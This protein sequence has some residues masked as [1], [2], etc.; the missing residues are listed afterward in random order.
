MELLYLVINDIGPFRGNHV[1]DFNGAEGKTGFAIFSKNG[2]G[3]T[4]LFN[5][6]QWCLFGEVYERGGVRSGK[7]ADGRKRKIV[8]E[9][10]KDKPL[11]NQDAYEEDDIP[12]MSVLII[13]DNEGEEI[14]ISRTAKSRV[15]SMPRHDEAME[16]RLQVT[17]GGKSTGDATSGQ[18]LIEELFPS[19]LR[20]FFFIDGESLEEYV[21][22]VKAGQVGGIKDDVEAVLRIPALTRGIDD[23]EKVRNEVWDELD[24]A[25]KR[26]SKRV[27]SANQA[28][29]VRKEMELMK[30]ELA[31][32]ESRYDNTQSKLE[33]LEEKLKGFEEAEGHI[34]NIQALRATKEGLTTSLGRSTESRRAYASNSWKSLIWGKAEL[35]HRDANSKM[36]VIQNSNYRIS[37]TEKRLRDLEE[38]LSKWSGY[39]SHCSQSIDDAE[40][41]KA[42]IEEKIEGARK[43]LVELQEGPGIS[44]K[45]LQMMIGDLVKLSPPSGDRQMIAKTDRDWMEDRA[46]LRDV[47]EKLEK[48]E[49]RGLEG[50]DFS[51]INKKFED[52]GAMRTSLSRMRPAIDEMKQNLKRAQL[53]YK[54]LGGEDVESQ[55]PKKANMNQTIGT[56]L[57]VMK[58]TLD[59]YR[60]G[61]RK[62]VE[63]IAS[64]TFRNVINAPETLT[65]LVIDINFNGSIVGRNGRPLSMPSSGQEMIMT[66]CIM[67]ALRQAS[68]VSAPIFFD[69]PGRSVDD[70]HKKAQLEYFWRVREHQF[71][72][73]PHTGEY[74]VEE[75]LDDFGGLIG[76][77][78]ELK[79]P[80]DYNNCIS[81]GVDSPLKKGGKMVCL[82]CN[83]EWVL[84]S[85]TTVEKLE[86]SA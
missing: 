71:V 60:E 64:T 33:D 82:A 22:L 41:H 79:W 15:G 12:E 49:E 52:R 77:A 1:F 37:T 57:N 59:E 28:G 45:A 67:D 50:L 61:A 27:K 73:F 39:C 80:E 26:R 72:I 75:T 32:R 43:D 31:G 81:C 51:D 24:K 76:G 86:V 11:M 66:M 14:Q 13:A 17:I 63:S 85:Q 53:D 10:P 23:L 19:E 40:G 78:W 16:I 68:G 36:V 56:L 48:E 62:E 29:D 5:A 54:K 4:S 69:T 58:D 7:W 21:N 3:K 47:S 9:W 6:M 46:K 34:K 8:G 55:D 20:R 18:A 2:R 42:L 83:H 44:E 38:E 74:R 30:A 35:L 70:D 65:G 84:N 25:K